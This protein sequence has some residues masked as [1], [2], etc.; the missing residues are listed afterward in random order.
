MIWNLA[1]GGIAAARC[2][3]I[4]QRVILGIDGEVTAIGAA[5]K[6]DGFKPMRMSR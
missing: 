4:D 6:H 2:R 5:G 3:H 1:V